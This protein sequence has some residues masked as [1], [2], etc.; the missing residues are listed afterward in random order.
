MQKSSISIRRYHVTTPRHGGG[1]RLFSINYLEI[2]G[3]WRALLR[4]FQAAECALFRFNS[5]Y[6]SNVCLINFRW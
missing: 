1:D 2:V 5:I 3:R 4:S 6:L